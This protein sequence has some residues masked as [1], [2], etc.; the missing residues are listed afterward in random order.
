MIQSPSPSNESENSK[1]L[2]V[3]LATMLPICLILMTKN[4]QGTFFLA[5]LQLLR[6][7]KRTKKTRNTNPRK[8]LH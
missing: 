3:N 5:M 1:S 7:Y 6:P 8:L 2:S 4:Q